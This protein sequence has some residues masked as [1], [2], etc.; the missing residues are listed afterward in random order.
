MNRPRR[1]RELEVRVMFEPNRFIGQ[2]L[3]VAYERVVPIK[4]RSIPI[5]NYK[6]ERN[7]NR[8][9]ACRAGGAL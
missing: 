6:Q 1:K 9:I 8:K 4:R 2:Y 5:T 7:N 3:T